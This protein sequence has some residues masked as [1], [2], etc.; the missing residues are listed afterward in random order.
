MNVDRKSQ[1][2]KEDVVKSYLNVRNIFSN[3]IKTTEPEELDTPFI[4][5]AKDTGKN[6]A[7]SPTLS[8]RPISSSLSDLAHDDNLGSIVRWHSR[9]RSQVDSAYGSLNFLTDEKTLNE[10]NTSSVIQGMQQTLLE[11]RDVLNERPAQKTQQRLSV[12]A[13]LPPLRMVPSKSTPTSRTTIL[14]VESQINHRTSREIV[15]GNPTRDV[16]P[17]P[18]SY[19]EQKRER[20]TLYDDE[21]N[22]ISQYVSIPYIL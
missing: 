14:E 11:I 10:D 7:N 8:N 4:H 12:P 22:K 3:S 15:A 18:R 19:Q 2:V 13:P 16:P 20:V 5:S 6:F 9:S 21:G 1:L 17:S